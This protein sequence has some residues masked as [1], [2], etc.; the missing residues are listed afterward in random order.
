MILTLKILISHKYA[1]L[2]KQT[3]VCTLF[4]MSNVQIL[5]SPF[6]NQTLQ[7]GN[8][9]PIHCEGIRLDKYPL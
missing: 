5:I 9:L 2:I 3:N 6:K 7:E 1:L 8:I 4:T